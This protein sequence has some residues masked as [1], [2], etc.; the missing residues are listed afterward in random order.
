MK[1]KMSQLLIEAFKQDKGTHGGNWV[2]YAP[3]GR[4]VIDGDWKL[5]EVAQFLIDRG[6]FIK[7]EL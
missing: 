4:T 2:D 1:Q 3:D 5:E 6:L 7:E